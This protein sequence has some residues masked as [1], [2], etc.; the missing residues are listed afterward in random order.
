MVQLSD[1]E[2]TRDVANDADN[3]LKRALH[4]ITEK[5]PGS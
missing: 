2:A 3:R 1:T 4:T 5:S